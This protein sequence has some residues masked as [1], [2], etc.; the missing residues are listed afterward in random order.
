MAPSDAGT[1]NFYARQAEVYAAETAGQPTTDLDRFL[2]ALPSGSTILELGCGS[3]RD[4]AHMIA[5]GFDAVPTDGTPEMALLAERR[6]GRPVAILP[7]DQLRAESQYDA[8][9]ANACLLHVPRPDLAGILS[10]IR[11]ATRLGGLFHASFKAG[12]ADGHDR[13]GRYY[14]YP[15]ADWLFA[16]Y[17]IAGWANILIETRDGSGYDRQPTQWLHVTASR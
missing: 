6:L 16:Q 11:R 1:L 2:D 14:N 15:S 4:S 5:R 3:G 10:S 9:W 7:F 12:T 13:F 8:V 17:S